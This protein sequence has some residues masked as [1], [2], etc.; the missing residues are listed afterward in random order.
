MLAKLMPKR[1]QNYNQ[2]LNRRFESR[3]SNK[4]YSPYLA[5]GQAKWESV[6]GGIQDRSTSGVQSR[7]HT[8]SAQVLQKKEKSLGDLK[9]K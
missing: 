6:Y 2:I 8:L 7:D 3:N 1:I 9:K 4:K 5:N